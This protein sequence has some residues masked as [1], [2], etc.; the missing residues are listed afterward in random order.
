MLSGKVSM[1]ILSTCSIGRRRCYNPAANSRDGRRLIQ[2]VARDADRPINFLQIHQRSHRHHLAAIVSEPEIDSASLRAIAK[3]TGCLHGNLPMATKFVETVHVQRALTEFC[4]IHVGQRNA[5][6]DAALDP[7]DL[8]Q[9]PRHLRTKLRRH[10]DQS[11]HLRLQFLHEFVGLALAT[12][13][14][15]SPRD[16]RSPLKPPATPNPGTGDAPKTVTTASLTCFAH[17]RRRFAII[18]VSGKF[19]R[20]SNSLSTINIDAYLRARRL[21][22]ERH[23]RKSPR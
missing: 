6:S 17:C 20:S 8:H 10:A 7:I 19:R 21:Q 23:A 1:T 5:Q 22:H 3:L 18:A 12:P 4:L 13:V 11:R 2:I 16:P 15:P 14:I 9:Q